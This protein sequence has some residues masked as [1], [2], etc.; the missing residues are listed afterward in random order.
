MDVVC[1]LVSW[2]CGAN[3]KVQLAASDCDVDLFWPHGKGRGPEF[4]WIL[5]GRSQTRST[6]ENVQFHGARMAGLI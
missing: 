1:F 3:L 5:P 6:E 4:V 2:S